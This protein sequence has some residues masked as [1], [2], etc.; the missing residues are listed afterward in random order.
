ML[1]NYKC[2][3]KREQRKGT[4]STVHMWVAVLTAWFP[5]GLNGKQGDIYD[6]ELVFRINCLSGRKCSLPFSTMSFMGAHSMTIMAN[7]IIFY[8][9]K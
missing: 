5:V 1:E 7:V 9:I 4:G 8:N 6:R 2:Y 3:E